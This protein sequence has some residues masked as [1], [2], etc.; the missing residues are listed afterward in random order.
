MTV[1]TTSHHRSTFDNIPEEKRQRILKVA[2][3][4]FAANGFEN[5]SIEK[6]AKKAGISV[7]SVYK[8]FERKEDMFITVVHIG[9][10]KLEGLLTELYARDEDV[11]VK[12]EKIIRELI[13]F[14]REEPDLIKLYGV[15]TAAK[16]SP[17]LFSLAQEMEAVSARIYTRAIKEGQKTGDVRKDIDPAF[18]AF[19]LDSLLMSLRFSYAS[20]Y[21]KERYAVYNGEDVFGDDEFVIEQTLKFIKA[22]FNFK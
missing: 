9:L 19:L 22:A 14:S 12:V 7:G 10:S 4:E 17:L 3:N 16:S 21:Y 13:K 1:F 15:L 5:T 20:D 8:Y 18:F 2:T 11:A 6:I